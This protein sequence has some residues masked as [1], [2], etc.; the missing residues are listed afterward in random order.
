MPPNCCCVYG[1]LGGARRSAANTNILNH[2]ITFST[3]IFVNRAVMKRDP[4]AKTVVYLVVEFV[5]RYNDTYNSRYRNLVWSNQICPSD[6]AI[7]FKLEQSHITWA[8]NELKGFMCRKCLHYLDHILRRTEVYLTT[9][10]DWSGGLFTWPLVWIEVEDF[11]LNHLCGLKRK[12]FHLTTC[13]DL[14]GGL[15]T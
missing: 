11:S 14:S 10:V 4:D 6:M 5:E 13:V 15:F 12:T 2:I 7:W 1:A 9:C 8:N 3:I